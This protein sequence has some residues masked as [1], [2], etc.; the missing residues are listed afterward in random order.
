MESALIVATISAVVALLSVAG[1][2]WSSRRNT[3]R[4]NI[5]ARAIEDLRAENE[6]AKDVRQRQREISKY[7]EPLARAAFDLQSRI[8]NIVRQ[9]LIHVHYVGGAERAR[10]YVV[11]NTCF[12][13]AQYFC[14]AELIRRDIQFIDLGTSDANLRLLRCQY[15]VA[16]AWRTDRYPPPFRIFVGEQRAVGEALLQTGPRGS[17]CMGYGAFLGQIPPGSNDLLDAIRA[18][19]RS[20]VEDVGAEPRLI[21]IQNGL[22]DLLE[23]LDPDHIRFD[24]DKRSKIAPAEAGP[25]G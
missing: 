20:L 3:E 12:L 14:W 9:G 7:S 17:E 15:Q 21:A 16:S 22:V 19:V 24:Q 13:I 4:A 10:K 2:V 5:N 1:N 23:L 18:D 6:Q 11:E 8:Y 25:T